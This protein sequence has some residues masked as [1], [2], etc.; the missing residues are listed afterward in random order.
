MRLCMV[1]A[2]LL[3][4]NPCEKKM[5]RVFLLQAVWRAQSMNAILLRWDGRLLRC[6]GGLRTGTPLQNNLSELWS[7]LN[8][9]LPDVFSNL[10]DFES[11]FDFSGVGEAGADEHIVA[12]E[13]RNRVVHIPSC[14]ATA[15]FVMSTCNGSSP[16]NAMDLCQL[17]MQWQNKAFRSSSMANLH[18]KGDETET[19]FERIIIRGSCPVHMQN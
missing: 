3:Y 4:I 10:A 16:W 13:Q 17:S 19:N 15:S 8:F 6:E 7:L 5:G 1:T 11:W 14:P 18:S 2:A 12:Q 9:L